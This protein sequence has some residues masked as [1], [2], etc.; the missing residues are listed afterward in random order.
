MRL[1]LRSLVS[2]DRD[3][4]P[5][6]KIN[7]L[8]PEFARLSDQQ[9]RETA[10]QTN[11]PIPFI[12]A[13][14]TAAARVLGQQMYDVQLRGALAMLRC[15]IAEMQT[16]EGKTLAAV[17]AIAWWARSRAG[18]HVMTVNDYLARRDAAWMGDIY[19]LLGFSVAH[20][21][22]AMGVAERRAAYQADITYAT[23]NEIGFDFLRDRMALSL[24]DQVHRRFAAA[25]VDEADS[26]LIDEARVPLVIAGGDTSDDAISP[27]ANAVAESLCPGV[28]YTVDIGSHNVAL[29]DSGIQAVETALRCG[30]LFEPRNLDL[31]AAVQDAL[32]AH[33]LV[34]R[35]VD[36][37]V[38]DDAIEMVDEFKGRVA[39]DRRWPANLQTA[40]EI[41]EGVARQNQGMILGQITLQH[42]ILMYPKIC[43][44][45]GTALTQCLELKSVYGIEVAQIPTNRPIVR[46]DEP[47]R[48][49]A[50]KPMKEAAV[51]AE[52][53]R[54]HATGQP[55]LVGT[56][57]V[58]ESERLSHLLAGIPHE[59]LNARHDEREAAIIARAGD[60]GAVTISTNMAGRGTDIRLGQGVGE[61]G[62]LYV[63]GTN[64]HE[65]RRIDNQLRGRAGRQGDPGRS[66]FFV[67]L[68]DDLM[69]KYGEVMPQ[70]RDQ[71]AAVQRLVEGQ[72]LDNRLFLHRYESPL[73]GQRHKLQCYRQS[74]L[75]SETAERERR[76]T[77]R[78]IDDAW[79][80]HLAR[81]ADFRSECS[82]SPGRDRI[83]CVNICSKCTNGSANW[84]RD[85]RTKS[86]GGWTR[87]AMNSRAAAPCGR[88]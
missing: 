1:S 43:G 60:L 40:I 17:P 69:V 58:Q 79:A 47:D 76:I 21:E 23:A 19:R 68:E 77:L 80:E 29:T 74:V 50:T 25:V 70:Y 7:R 15:K 51:I 59:V 5:I 78:A 54:V 87:P 30:N 86:R 11:D 84:K 82:G 6:R 24:E 33:T 35:D 48:V 49:F 45:T 46:L 16:G 55:V 67:S 13:V 65:S 88:I 37:L 27:A 14:A 32:H 83:R 31:H 28:H 41:K 22:Q 66:C 64:K 36:Y 57:S 39:Q 10:S 52:I 2:F 12:A 72:H 63:I 9:L 26:I 34:H 81:I 71:P 85:Y 38:K 62:G 18:V 42:L 56:A 4:S 61:L 20:V 3:R 8:R 73:E 75:E 44:M 53:R